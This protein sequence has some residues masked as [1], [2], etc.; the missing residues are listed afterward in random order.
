[1]WRTPFQNRRCFAIGGHPLRERR[2]QPRGRDTTR[3]A[4]R[5]LQ[6][7]AIAA[8][9]NSDEAQGLLE[10]LN[11]LIS[12]GTRNGCRERDQR[13]Q[14][15]IWNSPI[16]NRYRFEM[17]RTQQYE[18]RIAAGLIG[19]TDHRVQPRCNRSFREVLRSERKMYVGLKIARSPS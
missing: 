18:S 7:N 4:N 16:E 9:T 11:C 5:H 1:M 15:V 2:F 17:P 8:T 13:I 12:R 19:W 10:V 6:V 3:E 14:I